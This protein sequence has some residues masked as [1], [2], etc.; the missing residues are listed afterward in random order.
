MA[1]L[2]L[3]WRNLVRYRMRFIITLTG[4]SL[5]LA[6]VQT[7]HNFTQGV[8]SYMVETGVRSGTG[9]MA[10]YKKHYLENHDE[11][12]TFN[13][14]GLISGILKIKGVSEVMPR[15]YYSG[16]GQSSRESRNIFIMGIDMEKE[17]EINP[18]L[19]KLPENT[20]TESWKNRDALVG[21]GLLEELKIGI[22]RK[23]V[24]TIQS[25]DG[26]LVTELFRVGGVIDTGIREM[27]SSIV[28]INSSQASEMAGVPDDIHEIAVVL[29]DAAMAPEVFPCIEKL[30]EES[31]GLEAATWEKAMP[32]LFNAL[33]WDYVSVKV[34]SYVVLLIVTI[35]VVN[36]L[37]MSVTE[38]Y[39]EFGMLRG[40]GTS[41]FRLCRMIM[42]EALILGILAMAAGT[43]VCSIATG[44]LA[45][46]GFDLRLF[47]PENLEFGGVIFSSLLYAE[48]DFIWMA[49]SGAYIVFLC[50]AA[51]LYP[52]FKAARVTPVEAMRHV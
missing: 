47:I 36:T 2:K 33:R 29:E 50:L 18:F 8:Y 1:D 32:N 14:E 42:L 39:H 5:S 31:P 21:K 19:K 10:I 11:S 48:W 41:P 37:L 26:G 17:K 22:G 52:A 13:P 9:H 20:I 15:L 7:Y 46:Y 4:V 49:E 12:M 3:A 24:V 16:L 40:I 51:S 45:E 25:Q 30:L 23:F 6:L 43:A 44:Y 38:R 34:L 28:M 27:D 35:G